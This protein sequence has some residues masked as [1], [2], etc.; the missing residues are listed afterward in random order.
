MHFSSILWVQLPCPL[1]VCRG[2][3]L[4]DNPPGV[5]HARNPT[6]DCQEDVDDEIGIATSLEKNSNGRNEDGDDICEDVC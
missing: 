1:C 4:R 5:N 3:V 6:Q 2:I